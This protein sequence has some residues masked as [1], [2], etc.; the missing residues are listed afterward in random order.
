MPTTKPSLCVVAMLEADE[1][2]NVLEAREA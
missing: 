2:I 1:M